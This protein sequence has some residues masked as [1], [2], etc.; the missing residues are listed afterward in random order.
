MKAKRGGGRNDKSGPKS[1]INPTLESS[2][3]IPA[4]LLRGIRREHA[5]MVR[6]RQF[7]RMAAMREK[8]AVKAM[9]RREINESRDE[10]TRKQLSKAL[11][12]IDARNWKLADNY[13]SA[14][15]EARPPGDYIRLTKLQSL[16]KRML[17]DFE[18]AVVNEDAKWFETQAAALRW[19]DRR[20]KSQK[21]R[22]R[23]DSFILRQLRLCGLAALARNGRSAVTAKKVYDW[24][25]ERGKV[26]E[27]PT[28]HV[29][30][31]GCRFENAERV[32]QEICKL[33]DHIPGALCRQR[34]PLARRFRS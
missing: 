17:A 33:A 4:R 13:L 22:A 16:W 10:Q 18:R 2:D 5:V 21:A 19:C 27:S 7:L 1:S 6:L 14:R 34:H 31:L 26:K 24:L 30:V 12:E 9:C 28:G 29:I 23:F 8:Q 25:K 32:Q 15:L 3:E 11:A 20:D